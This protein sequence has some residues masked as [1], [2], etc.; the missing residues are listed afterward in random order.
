[1]DLEFNIENQIITRTDSNSVVNKSRNYLECNFAFIS[2]DWDDVE[3]FAMF[4]NTRGNNY[5]INLGTLNNSNCIVPSD[6]L[7]GDYFRVSVYGGDLITTNSVKINLLQSGYS[8]HISTCKKYKTDVFV[9]IFKKLDTKFEVA[10]FDGDS[11]V[12]FY[13][14]DDDN[15]LVE[16]GCIDLDLHNIAHSGSYNDLE[17]VP[18]DIANVR[19]TISEEIKLSYT[20]LAGAILSHGI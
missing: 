15:E 12:K 7:L 4:K 3:K 9:Q 13:N 10:S 17:D 8:K 16:I 18:E 20:Q 11:T 5:V 19:D 2:S 1:M 14:I 6:V